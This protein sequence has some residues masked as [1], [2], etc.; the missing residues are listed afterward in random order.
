M[1]P[2]TSLVP[3][4]YVIVLTGLKQGYEDFLRHKSDRLVN[5]APVIVI[6]KGKEEVVLHKIHLKHFNC[7]NTKNL[8][9]L[10]YRTFIKYIL[11]KLK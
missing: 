6:R 7:P 11:L 3:L 1:D 9:Q 5:N 2:T 8:I 4:V 10:Y